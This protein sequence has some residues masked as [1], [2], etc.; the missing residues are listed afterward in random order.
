M[1]FPMILMIKKLAMLFQILNLS[2]ED[3][4]KI[5]H[6]DNPK[7][8]YDFLLKHGGKSRIPETVQK[9]CHTFFITYGRNDGGSR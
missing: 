5:N 4:V 8:K 7:Y 2:I 6:L 1:D 3:F 9:L